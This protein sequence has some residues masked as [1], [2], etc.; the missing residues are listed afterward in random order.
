MRVSIDEKDDGY[1]AYLAIDRQINRIDV[2]LDDV[3]INRA[4]TAD[5]EQGFIVQCK[6]D[7]NGF[8]QC[9]DKGDV[10][11]ETLYGKV[12]IV[13]TPIEST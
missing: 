3:R 6:L 12:D 11:L 10:V 1:L 7:S 2:Y 13:L 8:V 5:D 4:I 9:D